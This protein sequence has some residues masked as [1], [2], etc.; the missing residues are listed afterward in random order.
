MSFVVLQKALGY[1]CSEHSTEVTL[2]YG[3]VPL[4]TKSVKP[5]NCLSPLQLLVAKTYHSLTKKAASPA[6]V[7]CSGLNAKK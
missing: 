4:L 6:M 1:P 7:V 2:I 3:F 5:I